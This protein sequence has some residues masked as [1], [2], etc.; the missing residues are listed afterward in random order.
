[1]CL[2]HGHE[3]HSSAGRIFQQLQSNSTGITASF[4]LVPGTEHQ[5]VV[6]KYRNVQKCRVK[7]RYCCGTLYHLPVEVTKIL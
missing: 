1:M 5:I 2:T 6:Q 4:S 3:K 7:Y